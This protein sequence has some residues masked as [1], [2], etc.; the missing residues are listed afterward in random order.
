MSVRLIGLNSCRIRNHT[1]SAQMFE[2][3]IDDDNQTSDRHVFLVKCHDCGH[4]W[5]E[6]W[7]RSRWFMKNKGE[8]GLPDR[9]CSLVR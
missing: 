1:L 5:K 2:K 6:I 9:G 7:T 4:K 8:L 3:E